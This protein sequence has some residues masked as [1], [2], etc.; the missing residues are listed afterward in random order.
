VTSD[1]DVAM[2]SRCIHCL[3]EHYP[4]NV[5]AVSYGESACHNCGKIS[6]EMPWADYVEAL[7]KARERL[8]AEQGAARIPR[9]RFKME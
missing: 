5:I 9:P 2:Q 1:K 6:R 8:A 7:S 4:T 3:T